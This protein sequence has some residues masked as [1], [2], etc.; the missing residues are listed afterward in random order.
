[1]LRKRRMTSITTVAEHEVPYAGPSGAN[2][3][4][5]GCPRKRFS[6]LVIMGRNSDGIID[7]KSAVLP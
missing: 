7:I 4:L 6:C 3:E 2:Q 5:Y 1:M